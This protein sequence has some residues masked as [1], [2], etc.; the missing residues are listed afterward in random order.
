MVLTCFRITKGSRRA[1]TS[2]TVGEIVVTSLASFTTPTNDIPFAIALTAKLIAFKVQRA[3]YV[4]L[5]R[6]GSIVVF[7]RNGENRFTTE[8]WNTKPKTSFSQVLTNYDSTE[9][10][11]KFYR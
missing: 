7:G 9:I 10:L 1:V 3:K 6:Q 5:A 2:L 8:I 4:T 11:S